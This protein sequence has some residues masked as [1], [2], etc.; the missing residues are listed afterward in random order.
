MSD[1]V[2][3]WQTNNSPAWTSLPAAEKI[4]VSQPGARYKEPEPRKRSVRGLITLRNG[5]RIIE[6]TWPATTEPLPK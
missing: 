5:A 2:P 4:P 1:S 3:G 6:K